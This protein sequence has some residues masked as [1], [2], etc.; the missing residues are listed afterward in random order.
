MKF[1]L[2]EK[3]PQFDF[4]FELLRAND[5]FKWKNGKGFEIAYGDADESYC[6]V[7]SIEFC[8]SHGIDCFPRNIPPE[9][10]HHAN[11]FNVFTKR[12]QLD[13]KKSYYVKSSTVIKDP[14]NGKHAADEIPFEDGCFQAVEFLEEGYVAEWRCFVMDK[15]LL[16]IKQYVARDDEALFVI[17]SRATV[18]QM[19][20]EF[21]SAPCAY[22]LDV[23]VDSAGSTR[24]IEVHDFF[25]CGLYKFDDQYRLP[26]M[27]WNWYVDY[28]KLKDMR[29]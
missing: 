23:G 11:G 10:K 28:R 4:Q 2:P 26:S 6:P 20:Q 18:L 3:V 25:A 14:K 24:I 15:Q 5:F 21:R 7:G 12:D 22:T 19:I 27:L 1:L 16:D 9:L 17:P 29:K 13:S 8:R